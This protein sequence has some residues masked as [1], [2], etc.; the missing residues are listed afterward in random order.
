M[1]LT[2]AQKAQIEAQLLGPKRASVDG[3]LVETRSASE[4]REALSL[5]CELEGVKKKRRGI[6]F[7]KLVPPAT[8]N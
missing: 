2:E 5:M 7:T 1:A 6:R 3:A 8:G 4:L